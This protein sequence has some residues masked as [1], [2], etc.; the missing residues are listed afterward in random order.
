MI[1][2]KYQIVKNLPVKKEWGL[3]Q[4]KTIIVCTTQTD[5]NTVYLVDGLNVIDVTKVLSDFDFSR[6]E[7]FIEIND[8]NKFNKG[9]VVC[10]K[11]YGICTITGEFISKPIGIGGIKNVLE[12]KYWVKPHNHKTEY[13][14]KESDLTTYTE[15][16]FI[17][18]SGEIQ[19]DYEERETIKNP[20]SNNNILRFR[21]GMGN[22]YKTH[23]EVTDAYDKIWKGIYTQMSIN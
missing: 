12:K 14:V 13:Q 15:Y 6:N 8:K 16:W 21:K 9:D 2:K 17:T 23:K 20:N 1:S 3:I 19:K 11:K 4:G 5:G 7:F 18:S 10:S 22:Y